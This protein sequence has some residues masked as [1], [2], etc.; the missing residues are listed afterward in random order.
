MWAN[1]QIFRNSGSWLLKSLLRNSMT[2]K[3][4]KTKVKSAQI[5]HPNYFTTLIIICIHEVI[6]LFYLCGSNTAWLWAIAH[7]FPALC[8]VRSHWWL[9][10]W[11]RQGYLHC[12]NWPPP[13]GRQVD[14]HFSAHHCSAVTLLGFNLSYSICQLCDLAKILNISVPQ[15]LYKM[16]ILLGLLWG[17]KN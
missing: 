3:F 13:H 1:F 16:H 11:P 7:L 5:H 8:S 17:L 4:I 10:N 15:F 9:N 14:E 12:R 2:F 6:C